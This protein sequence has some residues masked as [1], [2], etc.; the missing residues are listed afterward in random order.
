MIRTSMAT[1]LLA[2]NIAIANAVDLKEFQPC[3]AAAAKLCDRSQ[4]TTVQ[5]LWKCGATLAARLSEVGPRCVVV[6]KR[7][8]QL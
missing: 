6:L 3:R 7:Y 1:L 2:S 4:G 5:A 8:G